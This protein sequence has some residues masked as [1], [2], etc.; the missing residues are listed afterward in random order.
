MK[1]ERKELP[2]EV[3]DYIEGTRHKKRRDSYLITVLQM[4][5]TKF[6]YLPREAMDEVAQLMQI[7]AAKVTGVATFYHFFSFAPK[8]E[9]RITVCMGTACFVRGA[10]K[11]VEKIR[12]LLDLDKSGMSKDG[13]FSL[14]QARCLGACALAPVVVV[15]DKVFGNVKTSDVATILKDYGYKAAPAKKQ[16]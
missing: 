9:T 8:G 11:V 5:Q 3:V 16:G 2:P 4:I 1:K 12:E 6:G 14:E 10:E 13:K 7:P 15:N